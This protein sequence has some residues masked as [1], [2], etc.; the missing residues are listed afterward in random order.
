MKKPARFVPSSYEFSS[1]KDAENK[2]NG[3]FSAG[4]LKQK[5]KVYKVV[6][7]YSMHISLKERK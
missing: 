5:T 3:W 1:M 6:K 7:V 4:Q 2:L